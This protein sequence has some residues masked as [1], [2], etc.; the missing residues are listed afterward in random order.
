MLMDT[1]LVEAIEGTNQT[2]SMGKWIIITKKHNQ[3]Q[4]LTYLKENM[5]KLYRNQNGQSKIIQTGGE[6]NNEQKKRKQT[7]Y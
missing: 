1:H 6:T 5:L 3:T 4:M 2:V 7:E